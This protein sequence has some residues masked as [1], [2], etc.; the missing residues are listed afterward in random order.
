MAEKIAEN[1]SS[2]SN[3]LSLAVEVSVSR[4]NYSKKPAILLVTR[5]GHLTEPVMN[6]GLTVAKRLDFRLLVT[7]INTMPLLWDGGI[8]D[9]HFAEAVQESVGILKM[10]ALTKGILVNSVNDAGK[11]GK[12]VSRLC[13]IVKNIELVII[14]T[15]VNIDE[16]V[17]KSPVP[18]FTI[19]SNELKRQKIAASRLL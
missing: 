6:Y 12:V 9:R 17:S 19:Y 11:V 2:Y 13:R 4:Q 7:Y 8:R 5:N 10:K 3:D 18:V 1:R 15:G 16:V 14:D